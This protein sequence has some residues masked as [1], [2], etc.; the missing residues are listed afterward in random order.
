MLLLIPLCIAFLSPPAAPLTPPL[1]PFLTLPP[2]SKKP[3]KDGLR[4]WSGFPGHNLSRFYIL[5]PHP[6]WQVAPPAP[7]ASCWGPS[8]R[9]IYRERERHTHIYIYIYTHIYY[10]HIYYILYTTYYMYI[11]IYICLHDIYIY[12]YIYNRGEWPI[13]GTTYQIMQGRK[14]RARRE[15]VTFFTILP[16]HGITAAATLSHKEQREL[17]HVPI[18]SGPFCVDQNWLHF[19]T[20]V[21]R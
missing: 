17:I 15:R 7:W 5:P 21:G 9:Y 13:L 18:D 14:R 4:L 12:I 2:S 6:A 16:T 8:Y 11:Y 3:S 19:G 1:A 10:I 20:A